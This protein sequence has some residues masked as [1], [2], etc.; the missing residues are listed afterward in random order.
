VGTVPLTVRA[1]AS[2]TADLFQAQDS[3]STARFRVVA[4]GDVSAGSLG[5]GFATPY[6]GVSNSI[7][8][9]LT[10]GAANIGIA[11]RGSS[12]QTANMLEVQNS[13]STTVGRLTVS[14]GAVFSGVGWF[15]AQSNV[16]GSQIYALAATAATPGIVIQGAASQTA[17]L[18]QWRNSAGTIIAQVEPSG[19]IRTT[20]QIALS[21]NVV[22]LSTQNSGGVMTLARST[23]AASNPGANFARLYLRDGTNAGTLKLV[24]RAGAAGAETTILDNIPQ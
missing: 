18:Q 13:G 9:I 8:G 24:V 7:L 5:L 22:A 14:G 6:S 3:T 1:V 19:T 12:G 17:D 10:A 23:A 11:V 16:T 15:G 2:Q 21:G 4:N 20:Q